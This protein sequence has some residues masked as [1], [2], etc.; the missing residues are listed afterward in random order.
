VKLE[1]A[2]DLPRPRDPAMKETVE[3][4]RYTAALRQALSDEQLDRV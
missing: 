4:A 3:F 1:L 2:I